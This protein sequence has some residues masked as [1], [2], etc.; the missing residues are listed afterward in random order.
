MAFDG[1]EHIDHL[2]VP[3]RGSVVVDRNSNIKFFHQPIEALKCL[4]RWIGCDRW[5][6]C[7][8]CKLK[9]FAVGRRIAAKL[10][11]AV[12]ADS[13]PEVAYFLFHPGNRNRIG[14]RRKH[15]AIKLDV[16]ES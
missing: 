4:R 6:P 7:C 14:V 8:F 16:L 3:V 13:E 2:V 10:I 12:R 9:Y 1:V 15:T 11:H 5:N